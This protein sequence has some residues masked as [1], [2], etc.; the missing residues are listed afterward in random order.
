MTLIT[1]HPHWILR[2]AIELDR[3]SSF[4]GEFF[5]A[6][7]ERQ[8]VIAAYLSAQPQSECDTGDVAEFLLQAGHDDILAAAY[9]SVPSGLRRSLR[10][11]GAVVHAERFYGLLVELLTSGESHIARCIAQVSRVDLNTLLAIKALPPETCSPKLLQALIGKSDAE[12]VSTAFEVLVENGVDA[13]WLAGCL[14]EVKTQRALSSVFQKAARRANA[15]PHPIPASDFYEPIR[16]G[17]ELFSV[18]REF[19]N[20]LRN[21]T[22]AFLDEAQGNAFAVVSRGEHRTV[23]HL[24]RGPSGWKLEG[25]FKPRNCRPSRQTREWIEAYLEENGVIVGRRQP[26]TPSGWDSLHNLICSDLLEYN[27]DFGFEELDD[28]S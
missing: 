3:H 7:S 5:R 13:D 1:S 27:L 21:Y 28:V 2:H 16:T 15:P 14:R 11:A 25:L 22:T 23:V 24:V 18:A 6:S 8:H 19:R 4:C 10:R 12:D 17:E 9:E 26:R 20:C